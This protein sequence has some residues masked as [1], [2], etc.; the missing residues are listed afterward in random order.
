MEEG[1]RDRTYN[2]GKAL[3][4]TAP[5]AWEEE[6]D[7]SDLWV[8]GSAGWMPRAGQETSCFLLEAQGQLVMLDA[9]TGVSNLGLAAEALK[10]H[11]RLTVLLS[12]YHLDHLV[13]L[14]YLKRFVADKRVD[15]YGPGRPVYQKTTEQYVGDLLQD[16]LYSSGPFGFARE[17]RYHDYGGQD[18]RVGDLPVTVR[19]QVHSSSSF[20]LRVG[21]LVT[22]ATDTSFDAAA[23]EDCASAK[24]L[25]HECWQLGAGDT[26]HTSIEALAAGL[27]RERFGRVLLVH[28]NPSWDECERAEAERTAAC[29]GM[30]LARDGMVVPL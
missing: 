20:E 22:Y 6:M 5:W 10:R 8:L 11:D 2:A 12:H 24:L 19:S 27:P 18:F 30:E 21:D 1:F 3:Q 28:H 16:A 7:F 17:V 13:G 9:G 4:R 26:R 29:H 25:L 23:W 15:V 14:M